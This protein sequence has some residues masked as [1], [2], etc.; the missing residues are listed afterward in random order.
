MNEEETIEKILNMKVIAVVG[1]SENPE[2]PSFRVAKYLLENNYEIIPINPNITSWL[3]KKAFPSISSSLT[4]PEVI[5]IF[6]KSEAVEEIVDEA[7]KVGA[8]AV[9]LQEGVINEKAAKKA[10]EA[11][12][13]VVMDRCMMKEHF[14]RKHN[15]RLNVC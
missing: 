11:G 5:D 14:Y 10:Q 6:R 15:R 8:K 9:W 4:K 2:R 12:L 3:G 1:I 7:I 13:L